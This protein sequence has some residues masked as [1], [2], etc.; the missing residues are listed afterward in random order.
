MFHIFEYTAL[1]I[2]FYSHR[3]V[4]FFIRILKTILG[5]VTFHVQFRKSLSISTKSHADILMGIA[6]DLPPPLG[7]FS[8]FTVLSLQISEHA[9]FLYSL[10]LLSLW[11]GGG[12]FPHSSDVNESTCNARDLGLIPGWE[13]SVFWPREFGGLYSPWGQKESDMTER[14]SLF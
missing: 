12:C 13:D 14:L 7:R 8:I 9:V 1:S 6:L 11:W 2:W 4:I 3:T 5:S 10:G